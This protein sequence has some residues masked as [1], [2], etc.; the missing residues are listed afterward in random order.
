MSTVATQPVI[1]PT[2]LGAKFLLMA[3]LCIVSL[4][5]LWIVHEIVEEREELRDEV[6]Q[7]IAQ[8]WGGAQQLS[9]PYLVIPYIV[10]VHNPYIDDPGHERQTRY[11]TVTPDKFDVSV[12]MA[13]EER[14]RSIYGT[15][16]YLADIS[17]SGQFTEPKLTAFDSKAVDIQWQ[18]AYLT[19][20][21]THAV[22]IRETKI[23]WD[24]D[25]V[26]LEPGAGSLQSLNSGFHASIPLEKDHKT[27]HSFTID[28][29]VAGSQS[30]GMEPV[31]S[32]NSFNVTSDWKNPSFKGAFL[33]TEQTSGPDG[34]SASWDILDLATGI[35]RLHSYKKGQALN[36]SGVSVQLELFEPK[37]IYRQVDRATKYGL[38]FI[39]LT[40][41]T[42]FILEATMEHR[43]H[44]VQYL[45]VG[46]ALSLFF[47]ILLAYAEHWGFGAA[48]MLSSAI[49]VGMNGAYSASI[50]KSWRHA[51]IVGAVQMLLFGTLYILLRS[52]D[53][54]MM[55]GSALLAVA[56]GATMYFTRNISWFGEDAAIP[57]KQ[58]KPKEEPIIS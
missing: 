49:V 35:P 37:N 21:L 38:L 36:P 55:S 30:L 16:V 47:L 34:F 56:L 50:L 9:G 26:P 57:D 28:I 40:F 46:L 39:A 6:E 51:S 18:N 13:T 2:G 22:G 29:A 41:L 52:E 42:L 14:T 43:I 54:G 44:F 32:L 19:T 11:L 12:N 3:A 1:D 48:Y 8:G 45:L 24:G 20:T 31:G 53:T 17:I 58:P 25:I 33:P 15:P 27:G 7:D 10:E 4:I 5:P 23:S